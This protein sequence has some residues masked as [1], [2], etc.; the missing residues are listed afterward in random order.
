MTIQLKS[1]PFNG[2]FTDTAGLHG[3]SGVYAILEAL[4]TYGQYKVIDVG[5]SG[6]VRER[7]DNHDRKDC[8]RRHAKGQL[9]VAAYYCNEATRV[10]I[11]RELRAHFDPPCGKI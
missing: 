5:E 11:E 4:P 9:S 3:Q 8:W 2:P 7:V 6:N 1:Y 10:T